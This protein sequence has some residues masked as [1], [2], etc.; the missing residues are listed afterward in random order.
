MEVK[1]EVRPVKVTQSDMANPFV[2]R[3]LIA[4]QVY[5]RAVGQPRWQRRQTATVK[6]GR[7]QLAQRHMKKQTVNTVG[8]LEHALGMEFDRRRA[9]DIGDHLQSDFLR[10]GAQSLIFP[11]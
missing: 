8:C 10:A 7:P 11:E 1:G 9:V 2:E 6:R 5:D 4:R 3:A